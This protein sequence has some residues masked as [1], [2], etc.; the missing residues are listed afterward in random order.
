MNE[1]ALYLDNRRKTSFMKNTN[2][3]LIVVD[4]DD[5]DCSI[6]DY[7]FQTIDWRD[8]V[9]FLHSGKSLFQYLE[10]ISYSNSFPVLILLDYNMPNFNGEEILALLKNNQAYQSI[11][12]VVYSSEMSEALAAKLRALGA[13]SCY[14]KT[15]SLEEAIQLAKSL[16]TKVQLNLFG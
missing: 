8:H 10:T 7:S 1:Y 15:A 12:V 11:P 6:M 2:H 9:T 5:D 13:V 14:R 3:H 4:D 16:K